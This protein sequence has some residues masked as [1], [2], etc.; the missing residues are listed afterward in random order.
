MTYRDNH[1]L[2]LIRELDRLKEE[3]IYLHLD[4]LKMNVEEDILLLEKA[5]DI[6]SRNKIH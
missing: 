4:D 5:I 6:L 3:Y 1:H 2:L